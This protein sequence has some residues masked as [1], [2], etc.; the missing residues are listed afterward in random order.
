MAKRGRPAGSRQKAEPASRLFYRVREVAETM[1]IGERTV[2]DHVYAGTI[3]SRKVGQARLIPAGWVE[4][5]AF[6]GEAA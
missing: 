1:G 6:P 2:W 4:A 5:G 3:P